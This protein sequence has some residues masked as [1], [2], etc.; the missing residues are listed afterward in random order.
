MF[1]D[2]SSGCQN[3]FW[4]VGAGQYFYKAC[5]AGLLFNNV[6][7]Y[8]DWPGA[9]QQRPLRQQLTYICAHNTRLPT[10]AMPH[11]SQRHPPPCSQRQVRR[12][13]SIAALAAQIAFTGTPSSLVT[14]PLTVAFPCC[15]AVA[16]SIHQVG[17]GVS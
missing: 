4:C 15:L 8:C 17:M 11:C 2:Q 12:D 16:L 6:A 1:A 14:L 13:A 9:L 3:Y 5:A 10:F 7:Q